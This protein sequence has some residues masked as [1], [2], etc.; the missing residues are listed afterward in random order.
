MTVEFA[1]EAGA[2]GLQL[3]VRPS[4]AYVR[5][6]PVLLQRIVLNFVSNAIRYTDRGR[7]LVGCRQRGTDLLIAVWDTGCGIARHSRE[8]IFREF[9]QLHSPNRDRGK[10]LGLGLAIVARLAP[11]L[12]S[13][14]ELQSTPGKGSMFALRVPLAEPSG[15][16]K[17]AAGDDRR[18]ERLHGT[19][20]RGVFALIVD[21]DENARAGMQSLLKRWGCLVLAANSSAE[22]L[23]LLSRHERA[24]ELILCDY[25]LPAGESGIEAIRRIQAACG[26][27]IPAILVTGDTS[28]EVARAAE[29]HRH[30][31]IYKPVAPAKLRALL[32][33]VLAP[34]S[35]A[36]PTESARALG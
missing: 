17:A 8:E 35:P 15:T 16:G 19:P 30:P 6:D 27:A 10:G 18:G 5:S 33:Q 11:L 34:A 29:D 1:P 22:A 7:V 24:P 2:K 23:A 20:V 25:H 12:G 9:V 36:R 14:V 13:V 4:D 31:L 26:A 32:N 28:A 21:D 3:T